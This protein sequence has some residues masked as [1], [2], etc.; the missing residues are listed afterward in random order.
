MRFEESERSLVLAL[1]ATGGAGV[2]EARAVVERLGSLAAVDTAPA[3]ALREVPGPPRLRAALLERGFAARGS[4][5]VAAAADVGLAW[6][7]FG[8]AG[9]PDALSNLANPPL[10]LYHRG[11]L[12]RRR[13]LVAIV[14]S[15]RATRYGLR[16]ARRLGRELAEAGHGV[17][18]GLA[19]GVD[20]AAHAGCLEASAATW[21]VLGCGLASVYPPEHTRLAESVAATGGVLSE[22]P[23][24]T[25]PLPGHFPRRNRII[26]A[27]ADAVVLVEGKKKS[28]GLITVRQAADLGRDVFVVPGQID[29]PAAEG[30]L[31]LLR[32]GVRAVRGAADLI[33]DMGWG[34]PGEAAAPPVEERGPLARDEARILA[35]LDHEPRPLD[36]LLADLVEPP[37]RVLQL[38]LSLE[39]SGRVEQAPGLLFKRK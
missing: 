19:R 11:R 8:D 25:P 18:S 4:E 5:E 35:A 21:A 24:S 28:G 12:P 37:G 27:L 22:F 1:N 29:N 31:A 32:D 2:R 16:C 17:V 10:V 36:E 20:A 9:Y 7:L 33:E 38:L 39:L 30:V 26:A 13:G 15:R 6:T 23:P 3:R 14:G 34:E